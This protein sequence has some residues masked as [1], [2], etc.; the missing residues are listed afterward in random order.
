M[1]DDFHTH[2]KPGT[3]THYPTD[4]ERLEAAEAHIKRL[5]AELAERDTTMD[6]LSAMLAAVEAA[7]LAAEAREKAL[8][9]T[10]ERLTAELA[11]EKASR[12]MAEEAYGEASK[13]YAEAQA[14]E[15]AL[16]A[17]TGEMAPHP[18]VWDDAWS[19]CCAEWD[20]RASE[21]V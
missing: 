7:Y 17:V 21:I 19:N 10:I 20:L 14:R 12:V 16:R 13:W 8:R 6:T 2:P 9:L 11:E 15:K 18:R 3:F 1:S 5:T 4:F